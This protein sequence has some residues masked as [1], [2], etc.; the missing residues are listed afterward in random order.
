M[1]TVAISIIRIAV[2]IPIMI[3]IVNMSFAALLSDDVVVV[4]C[5]GKFESPM[6]GF[7]VSS[8]VLLQKLTNINHRCN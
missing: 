3:E 2:M 6:F 4:V 7:V 5:N 1:T 8:A